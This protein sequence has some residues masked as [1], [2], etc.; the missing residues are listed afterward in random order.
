MRPGGLPDGLHHHVDSLRQ[1]GPRRKHLIGTELEGTL[2]LGLAATGRPHPVAGRTAKQDERGGYPA[3]RALHQQGRPGLDA[4]LLEQH[5][6]CGQVGRRQAGRFLER[7]RR[8]LRHQVASRHADPL[9]EDAV[10]AFGKQ[11]AA[12][13]QGLVAAAGIRVG[14]HRVHD[15]LVAVRVETRRVTA[16]HDRQPVRGDAHPAQRPDVM[17]IQRGRLHR[18][19]RPPVGGHRLR[20]VAELESGQRIISV[21]TRG[22]HSEHIQHPTEPESRP[23]L[24]PCQRRR[25]MDA[26]TYPKEG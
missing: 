13:I 23:E 1:P 4:G 10:V 6:V 25:R 16:E 17:M 9:G 11:R 26:A 21:D 8:W 5:L 24:C 22:S 3:A 18:H 20:P 7:Q 12:W 15:D 2:A 19:R 14:D